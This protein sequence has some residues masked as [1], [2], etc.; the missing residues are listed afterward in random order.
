[1]KVL[2]G[3]GGGLVAYV[4]CFMLLRGLM[5]ASSWAPILLVMVTCLGGVTGYTV[6]LEGTVM[7]LASAFL[8]L[9][10]LPTLLVSWRS[11]RRRK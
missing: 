1:M 5:K 7:E 2:A 6:A 10:F 11:L 8:L 9:A 4:G 3:V